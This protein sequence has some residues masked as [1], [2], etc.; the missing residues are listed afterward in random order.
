MK[1]SL[2]IEMF[3][4]SNSPL[5]HHIRIAYYIAQ[6]KRNQWVKEEELINIQQHKLQAI[7]HHAYN[8]VPYYHEMFNA[9]GI[10]PD[11][12]K[13]VKD[14]QNLP[15]TTKK[16]LQGNYPD[17]IIAKGTDINRCRIKTTSGSTGRPLNI[18][19]GKKTMSYYAALGYYTFFESGLKLTDKV[20][21][22]ELPEQPVR[23][24]WFQRLGI[25]RRETLSL[26]EPIENIINALMIMKPDVIYCQPSML[27]VLAKEI[28]TK[29]ITGISPRIIITHAETLTDHSRKEISDA[30][31]TV[32]YDIYG[33]TESS[34]LAFQCNKHS[35]YHMISDS[36]II[37][38]IKDGKNIVGDEPGEIVITSLYNYE[39]PLIRYKLGDI[40]IPSSEKCNCGRTFPRLRSIEGRTDDFFTLPSG[41]TISSRGSR[42]IKYI[43]GIIEFR[44]I[45]EEKDRF[46]VQVV[47]GK[48]FSEDSISQ[49]KQQIRACCLGENVSCE[50]ELVKELPRERTGKLRTIVSKVR[51]CDESSNTKH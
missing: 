25:L 40:G 43:P 8:N 45:Q 39:M 17:K 7:V 42:L 23:N 11:D 26:R 4:P 35:G 37:E 13:T 15:I 14:L 6:L 33:S 32:I 18:C 20:V 29:N 38:F 28:V 44:I 3:N 48:E 16:E 19:L 22:F 50:V 34:S 30:F 41:R 2:G 9:H 46:I 47:K 12:I 31:K 51:S 24:A 27:S 36:V 49:I 10:K 5:A 1:G 21:S